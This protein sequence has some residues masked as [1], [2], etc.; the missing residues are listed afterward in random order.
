MPKFELSPWQIDNLSKPLV[1]KLFTQM[2]EFY[3]NPDNEK[4]F[5][6]WYIATY[7]KPVPTRSVML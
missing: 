3:K 2:Q 1:D 6:E 4:R 5:R 7:G